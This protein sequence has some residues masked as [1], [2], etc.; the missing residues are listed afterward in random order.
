MNTLL[1]TNVLLRHAKPTDPAHPTARAAI[2]TLQ[3]GGDT[4]CL[5][6]QNLYEFWAAA[7]RPLDANGLGLTAAECDAQLS[8]FEQLFRLLLDPPA[9]LAEWRAVVVA[10][11]CKGKVA[12]DARLVAAMTVLGV[13]RVLTFNDKDFRRYPHLTVLNPHAVAAAISGGAS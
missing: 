8:Q 6:P 13:T 7:T 11:D 10:H 5:F 9:L 12:H 3:A 2:S 4:L 1:D